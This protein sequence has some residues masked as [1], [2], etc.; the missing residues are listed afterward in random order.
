MDDFYFY[1]EMNRVGVLLEEKYNIKVVV[2]CDI[3]LQK[4]NEE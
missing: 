4:I 1:G 3:L 2:D